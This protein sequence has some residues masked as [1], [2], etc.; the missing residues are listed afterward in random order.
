MKKLLDKIKEF[1]TI[2]IHGHIR[3]D[4]DC[5]GTQYG[6]MYLI[7]ESFPSK[8]VYVTGGDS[9]Y[10]SFIGSPELI[11]ESLFQNALSICVDC[12]SLERLSDNRCNKAKYTIKI[13]HH[14]DSTKYCDYEYVDSESPSCTQIITEFYMKFKDELVMSKDAATALYVGLVTDTGRFSYGNITS[15]TFECTAELLEFGI[16]LNYISNSLSLETEAALRLKGY[17]LN[18]FKVTDNGFV[19]IVLRYDEFI[20]FGVG[21]EVASSLVTSISTIKEC[22][23]WALIIEN[24]EK[25]RIRLRSRGPEI[26]EL[27]KKY[28]GG[29][30][31]LA[32]GGYLKNWDELDAFVKLADELVEKYKKTN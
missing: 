18:N 9:K 2:I 4:G 6:L 28:N 17:C 19:Y 23:V 26:N 14:A 1:D 7:K 3:P 5:I 31:K 25:I 16:D 24:P 11:D 27:A 10:V 30:H 8:K 32:S 22:P 20:R 12:P 13:D 21:E 15:K 29:G